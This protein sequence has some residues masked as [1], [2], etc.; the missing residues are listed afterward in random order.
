VQGTLTEEGATAAA[1]AVTKPHTKLVAG[2]AVTSTSHPSAQL[3]SKHVGH[4]N[5]EPFHAYDWLPYG[6]NPEPLKPNQQALSTPVPC[7]VKDR[8]V[9]GFA[10][11]LQSKG[12]AGAV[13]GLVHCIQHPHTCTVALI[14][15]RARPVCGNG[16][17]R[18][19]FML[20]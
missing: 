14:K 16:S 19:C 11:D 10:Y 13:K 15:L 12:V 7:G 1:A 2:T 18:S 20:I 9:C 8:L 4:Q 5:P 3:L 17:T 6:P